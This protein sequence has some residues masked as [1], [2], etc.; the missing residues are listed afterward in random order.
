MRIIG[1]LLISNG[2][3]IQSKQMRSHS[4]VGD[5]ENGLFFLNK[6]SFIDEIFICDTTLNK[7]ETL[8]SGGYDNILKNNLKPISYAGFISSFEDAEKAISIGFDKVVLNSQKYDLGLLNKIKNTYGRQAVIFAIDLITNEQN[9]LSEFLWRSKK[10]IDL[11]SLKKLLEEF[12]PGEII[13]NWVNRDG[14]KNGVCQEVP[15]FLAPYK[16][17]NIIFAAGAKIDQLKQIIDERNNKIEYGIAIG[18][19]LWHQNLEWMI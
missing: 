7:G 1:K 10:S 11:S 19:A 15:K 17:N 9:C 13:V 6:W 14:K 8:L 18:T 16:K 5:L 12:L 2:R 3:L 4:I